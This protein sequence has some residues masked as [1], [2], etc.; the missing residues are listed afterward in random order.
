M[1]STSIHTLYTSNEAKA[2]EFVT[3]DNRDKIQVQSYTVKFGAGGFF[4]SADSNVEFL[5]KDA[6]RIKWTEL[7]GQGYAT[8]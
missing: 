7:K 2:V 8:R 5:T 4:L 1:E 6:A 3:F